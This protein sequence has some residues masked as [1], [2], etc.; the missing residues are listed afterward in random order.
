MA[1]KGTTYP[2]NKS[3]ICHTRLKQK[4]KKNT[5]ITFASLSQNGVKK[6][7]E[8]RKDYC[9]AFCVTSKCNKITKNKQTVSCT[10]SPKLKFSKIIFI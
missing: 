7:R 3:D 4:E 2:N 6:E 10:I 8:K 1:L 9:K 5:Q